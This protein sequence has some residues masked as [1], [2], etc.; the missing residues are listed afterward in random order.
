MSSNFP[1]QL[2]AAAIRLSPMDNSV[3][4]LVIY[5]TVPSQI[6]LALIKIPSGLV[7]RLLQESSAIV[8]IVD[9]CL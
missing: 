9:I 8:I 7:L 6:P 5:E 1:A 4:C 3:D 2:K